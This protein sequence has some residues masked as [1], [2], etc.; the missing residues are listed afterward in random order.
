[1]TER[2][3]LLYTPYVGGEKPPP[4]ECYFTGCKK[5]C[6]IYVSGERVYVNGREYRNGKWKITLRAL[7]EYWFGGIL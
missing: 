4:P 2:V 1:M 5:K 7:W 3:C 6:R